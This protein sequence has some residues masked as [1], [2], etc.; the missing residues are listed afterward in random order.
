MVSVVRWDF[1]PATWGHEPEQDLVD[2][3]VEENPGY[4][5]ETCEDAEVRGRPETRNSPAQKNRLRESGRDQ[6]A[7]ADPANS[8]LDGVVAR[9]A[10][11]EFC[12]KA[13]DEEQRRV[14]RRT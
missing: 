11:G 6:N 2:D 3:D 7:V 12:L 14:D 8:G 9:P 10:Q 5:R 4:E 1:W 13:V